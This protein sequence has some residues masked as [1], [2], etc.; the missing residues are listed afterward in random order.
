M[1]GG[2]IRV[3]SARACAS[4]I[5]KAAER[6]RQA[7]GIAVEMLVC[8]RHCHR[9]VAEPATQ[10]DVTGLPHF[11]TEVAEIEGL[12]VV[13]SGAGYL[14]DDAEIAGILEADHRVCLGYRRLALL[15]QPGNPKG[16]TRLTDLERSDVTIGI[17]VI[18]CLKGVHEDLFGATHRSERMRSRIGL[19]TN[20]CVALVESLVQRKV[21]VAVGWSAFRH[22]APSGIQ[23]VPSAGNVASIERETTASLRRGAARAEGAIQFLEFLRNGGA[24]DFLA[25]DGW[26]LPESRGDAH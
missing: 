9:A 25:G 1:K 22:L 10:A 2:A 20:G 4:P 8:S 16:I 14:T 5:G 11:L 18:D 13:V 24:D 7:A 26:I 15:V 17:S 21:D 6:F 19:R 23:V 12:D 3:F